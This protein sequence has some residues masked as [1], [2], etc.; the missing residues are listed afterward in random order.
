MTK[1]L[2]RNW[3][4]HT[5]R[6]ALQTAWRSQICRVDAETTCP[7]LGGWR[8]EKW[9]TQALW[10]AENFSPGTTRQSQSGKKQ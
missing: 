4:S 7:E 9:N 3:E 6:Q 2:R 1:G 8:K 5:H 10:V